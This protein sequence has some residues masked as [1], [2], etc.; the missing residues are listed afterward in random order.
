M[1][2]KGEKTST[3]LSLMSPAKMFIYNLA[4]VLRTI[5]EK[6]PLS[7]ADIARELGC[8]KSTISSSIN[9]LKQFSL[10]KSVGSGNLKRG[11]KSI[12][13]QFNPEAY[14]FVAVDLRWK[15]VNL[16]MVDMAGNIHNELTYRRTDTDP[17]LLIKK[18]YR[19]ILK[20]ITD[21]GIND[22]NIEG[23][24]IMVPGI[25][26][27]KEGIVKYSSTL[28][29]EEEVPLVKLLSETV[30]KKII[31]YNDA[32]ALALGEMWIGNGKSYS[33][34][35][36]IYTEGGLGGACLHNGEI[37]LGD[38]AAAG[39]FGKVLITSDSKPQ[40]S[41]YSLSLPY[42]LS[43]YGGKDTANME[44]ED[45]VKE[46]ITLL[47]NGNSST[48]S[49]N[50]MDEIVDKIAQIIVNVIAV[51]NP[52]IVIINCSYLPDP[53]AFLALVRKRVADYLPAK[54]HRTINIVNSK[55]DDR[56]EVVGA[57]AAVIN[58]SRF[59][60]VIHEEVPVVLREESLLE[61]GSNVY[62]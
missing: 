10:V 9:L 15:K 44:Y 32:N 11:R 35:A 33:N 55:L 52:Q 42:L 12:L 62:G 54:P 17:V 40:R 51:F 36:F 58:H 26:D 8:S 46:A 14:F 30:D 49:S 25:V 50:M 21:S 60:F 56:T 34:M 3:T 53:D 13:L 24:G 4:I 5:K 45:I 19:N 1:A 31:I 47:R 57:A 22:S 6:G 41:E 37:I 28:G 16:A 39:E 29:W 7:Q 20:I 18:M 38:N 43:R 2:A 59:H 23:I 61:M 27:T 48:Q